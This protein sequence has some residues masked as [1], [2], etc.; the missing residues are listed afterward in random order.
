MPCVCGRGDSRCLVFVFPRRKRCARRRTR[1]YRFR[2]RPVGRCASRS[3]SCLGIVAP[4][5]AYW[6]LLCEMTNL[7]GLGNPSLSARF[8]CRPHPG[9]KRGPRL[10][11]LKRG[12]ADLGGWPRINCSFL[13]FSVT[14][15]CKRSAVLHDGFAFYL[16]IFYPM[17]MLFERLRGH[18]EALARCDVFYLFIPPQDAADGGPLPRQD[19]HGGR[20][21]QRDPHRLRERPQVGVSPRKHGFGFGFGPGSRPIARPGSGKRYSI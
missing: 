8:A 5:G 7:L 11:E 9:P 2:P 20:V 15:I 16:F 3:P 14:S 10:A 19:L 6:C 4:A 13:S 18:R 1:V 12:K 17:E 21:L